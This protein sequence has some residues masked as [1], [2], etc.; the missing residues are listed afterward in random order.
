MALRATSEIFFANTTE[1]S[2]KA[3]NF[4]KAE[5]QRSSLL[6]LAE[7]HRVLAELRATIS[8]WRKL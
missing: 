7:S 8:E 5:A 1:A 6:L 3:M 2:E 4:Y